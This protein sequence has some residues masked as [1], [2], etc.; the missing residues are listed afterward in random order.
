MRVMIADTETTGFA[1]KKQPGQD[2]LENWPR[3][4]QLAYELHDLKAGQWSKTKS[5]DYIVYPDGYEIPEFV[6][7]IHG[8]S[9]ER[10]KKEGKSLLSVMDVFEADLLNC[11]VVAFHNSGFDMN[12]LDSEGYRV[13]DVPYIWPK[14]ICTK[15]ETAHWCNFKNKKGAS[16]QPKLKELHNKLFGY[17]FENAHNAAI[18]VAVTANCFFESVR[19]GIIKLPEEV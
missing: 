13:H 12:V 10:A 3:M 16:K 18:D 14:V 8:I 17:D 11:D 1:S 19:R 15:K 9:T 4:V 5:V 2:R 7:E 6:T